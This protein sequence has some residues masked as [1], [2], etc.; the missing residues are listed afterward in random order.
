LEFGGV[1]AGVPRSQIAEKGEAP[2]TRLKDFPVPPYASASWISKDPKIRTELNTINS[3]GK[4]SSQW[5]E[6]LPCMQ[7]TP[8]EVLATLSLFGPIVFAHPEVEVWK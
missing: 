3:L 6:H 5:L 2:E 1:S 8:V 4:F 7:E